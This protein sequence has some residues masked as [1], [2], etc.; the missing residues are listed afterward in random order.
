MLQKHPQAGGLQALTSMKATMTEP[1]ITTLAFRV[2]QSK[3]ENDRPP[4][5]V[6]LSMS[7]AGDQGK[8][9]ASSVT[10]PPPQLGVARELL[11]LQVLQAARPPPLAQ[12]ST[13]GGRTHP[14]QPLGGIAALRPPDGP[15]E[16]HVSV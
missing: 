12:L 9:G 11:E 4:F 6:N 13:T 15:Q 5:S 1:T 14:T 3:R 7:E 10:C 16:P 2:A 8:A